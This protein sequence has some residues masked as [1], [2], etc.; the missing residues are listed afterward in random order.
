MIFL[1]PYFL[2]GFLMIPLAFFL[3]KR[4]A[5]AVRAFSGLCEEK[6]L[7]FLLVFAGGRTGEGKRPGFGLSL[8]LLWTAGILF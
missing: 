1:R 4:G 6:F 8:S 7:P 3:Q 2:L 5:K